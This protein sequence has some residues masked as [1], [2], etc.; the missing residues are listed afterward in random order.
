MKSLTILSVILDLVILV[1]FLTMPRTGME[2]MGT[3]FLLIPLVAIRGIVALIGLVIAWRRRKSAFIAYTFVSLAVIAGLWT[4]GWSLKPTDKP[5]YRALGWSAREQASRLSDYKDRKTYDARRLLLKTRDPEHA[6][7]CDLLADER[8]V[9]LLEKQLALEPDLSKTCVTFDGDRVAPVLHAII[10]AYGPWPEGPT[11]RPPLD[12]ESLPAAVKL[13]LDHGA[14]PNAFDRHGNTPLHYA[15]I[16]Q[17]ER[18]VDVLL[19]G[20]A[21]VFLKNDKDES[22]ARLHSSSRLRKKIRAAANDPAMVARCPDL[23]RITAEKSD[24]TPD[25]Q[26]TG[27]PQLPPDE[28]LLDALRSG[29]MEEAADYLSQG[30][31]PNAVDRKGSTLQAAMRLCRDH[32]LAMMQMLLKAG[33]DVNLRNR[34]G[35]TPLKIAAFDCS[36][37]VPFLLEQGA[38]PTLA[39]N[40]GDTALHGIVKYKAETMSPLLD[41]LL[42]AGADINHQNR[43]GQTPLVKTAYAPY[44]RDAVAPLLLARGAD[45]NLQDYRGDTLLHILAAEKGRTNPGEMV[46]LLLDRGAGLEIRNRGHLTPLMAAAAR[47]NVKTAKMLIDAG[48]DVNVRSQRGNP[49]I[50]SLISCDPQKLAILKLLADASCDVAATIEYGP[51]PLAQAFYN[52]LYLDCLE[53][54]RILLAAGADPNRQDRN[55][56]APIHSLAYWSKKDPLPALAL[57]LDH[58][59]RID[60]RN[61]QAMT[62]LLLAARYGISVAPMQALLDRGADPKAVDENGNTL[63]HCVAMNTKPGVAERLAF[64]LAIG[65]DPAATNSK[66]ERPLDRARRMKN[67]TAVDA[68]MALDK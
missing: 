63:L 52:H 23:H 37:A 46:R 61:Q 33:A 64:A 60:I 30:A 41:G 21:C 43:H 44:V 67:L 42:Q 7:L 40:A 11:R 39:D 4:F 32:K 6:R 14:D 53:P 13:L 65:G 18:L 38:D 34:R 31:D 19:A 2:A 10:H 15:L 68:L 27:K 12:T 66:G 16:F 29:R 55:G 24:S 25:G 51:L 36:R 17:E 1:S 5:L 59:A 47:K 58:G 28:G 45:P 62:A 9:A 50:G 49:L 8:D 48:A 54:A 26:R 56:T 57:L 22:P 3:A 35:E 20:G